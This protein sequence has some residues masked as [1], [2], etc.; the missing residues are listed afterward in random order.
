MSPLIRPSAT[1]ASLLRL[2]R[3][4]SQLPPCAIWPLL[5]I[6]FSPP[7]PPPPPPP[8]TTHRGP[9]HPPSVIAECRLCACAGGFRLLLV[10][11]HS[12]C[13]GCRKGWCWFV[14]VV[15]GDD[16]HAT[17]PVCNVTC[18]FNNSVER[19]GL[20]RQ[21]VIPVASSP[22]EKKCVTLY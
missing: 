12:V 22:E 18:V 1:S 5:L 2:P 13:L 8:P 17:S 4:P 11:D 10:F 19:A 6:P 14:V 16:V 15:V 7:P 21:L 20:L 9:P 3:A